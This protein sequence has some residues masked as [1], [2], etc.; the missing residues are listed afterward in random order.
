MKDQNVRSLKEIIE[1]IKIH[2]KVLQDKF[3][4]KELGIFGSFV[5][6]EQKK[7]K[8]CGYFCGV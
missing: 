6:G 8:R 2:K 5:R 3:K 7:K 4:I 1:K